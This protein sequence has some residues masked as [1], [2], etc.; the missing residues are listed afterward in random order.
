MRTQLSATFL[1]C[2]L[3]SNVQAAEQTTL[4]DE[5]DRINYSI[6][7]QIGSDFKRQKIGLDEQALEQ[8][9]QDGHTGAAPLLERKEMDA[10][11]VDLKRK[12]STE[13]KEKATAR[14]TARKKDEADK[15]SQGAAFM[16]E[17][18]AKEGVK[19]M[20][21][22]LQ[23]KVLTPGSGRKPTADDQVT[24]NYQARTLSGKVFNSSDSKGKPASF[25]VRS[26]VPGLS[27]ALQM[28]QP[29]A[30]WELYLPPELAYGR[31]GPLAHQTIIIE[32]EL[33]SIDKPEQTHKH[34]Q[35]E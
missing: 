15:R 17:N 28:M 25:R 5:A 2:I 22:R 9:M 24:V 10:T 11:L 7:H 32:V 21:S 12:I 6:G 20:P 16:L 27:E 19:T 3:T 26:V 30:K 29:G 23:Y 18:Q 8:G 34:Q 4:S 13:M 1:V 31:Q 33:L 14:V 35:I